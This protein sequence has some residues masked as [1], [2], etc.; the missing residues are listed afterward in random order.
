LKKYLKLGKSFFKTKWCLK[1]F[2]KLDSEKI[3]NAWEKYFSDI[4]ISEKVDMT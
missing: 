4:G 3:S 2:K 1:F